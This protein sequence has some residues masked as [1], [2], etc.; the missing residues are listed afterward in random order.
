[1][2]MSIEKK[3]LEL[4]A[5]NNHLSLAELTSTESRWVAKKPNYP[6]E[7]VIKEMDSLHFQCICI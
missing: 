4:Q 3:V 7:Y 1:M 2:I 5:P 6:S